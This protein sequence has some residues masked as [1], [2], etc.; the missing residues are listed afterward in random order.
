ML[1]RRAAAISDDESSG[2][3]VPES[4]PAKPASKGKGKA[5]AE[6]VEEEPAAEDDDEEGDSEQDADEFVVEKILDHGFHG[7]KVTYKVKWLGYDK[8]DDMTWEPAEN[9]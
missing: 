8:E 6:P 4:I 1:T 3:E 2:S 9:L 7:K 5:R